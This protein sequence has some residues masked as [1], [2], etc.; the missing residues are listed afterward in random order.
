VSKERRTP[1]QSSRI[2]L[3]NL[4]RFPLSIIAVTLIISC[5][6]KPYDTIEIDELFSASRSPLFVP[7]THAK[8]TR[9]AQA[10]PQGTVVGHDI[11]L[12][13]SPSYVQIYYTADGPRK[14]NGD[15]QLTTL[16][17]SLTVLDNRGE[18]IGK[19][20]GK[21]EI[22][23][24]SLEEETKYEWIKLRVDL[25]NI[26]SRRIRLVLT[27]KH[28]LSSGDRNT[29]QNDDS[30]TSH[31][32]GSK[33]E[34]ATEY[35]SKPEI[36]GD[37]KPFS[38]PNIILVSLDTLRADHLGLYG[39]PRPTSPFL[40]EFGSKAV[41]FSNAHS[42]STWTLPSHWTMMTS[43]HPM[44]HKI[45]EY[46]KTITAVE[47]PTIAEILAD[48]LYQTAAFTNAGYLEPFFGF[49]IGFNHFDASTSDFEVF[50]RAQGWIDQHKGDPFFVFIH[51]FE[52]HNYPLSKKLHGEPYSDK[53]YDGN[54]QGNFWPLLAELFRQEKPVKIT[55]AD[56]AHAINL[57]DGAI[58]LTDQVLSR[59]VNYIEST[60]SLENTVIIITSDHGESFRDMHNG[61]EYEAWHH[62]N[63]PYEEQNHIP[64]II[65]VPDEKI[66]A[67]RRRV[68]EP[69][70]LIDLAPTILDFAGIEAPS[71]F[72]GGSLR[73]TITGRHTKRRTTP[74]FSEQ[75][76]FDLFSVTF[77]D[78]K[79]ISFRTDRDNHFKGRHDELYSLAADPEELT[80]LANRHPDVANSLARMIDEH[81]SRA[82]IG[83]VAEEG[84]V[85]DAKTA[86]ELK[87]L[88]YLQ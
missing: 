67:Q 55:D 39:Y 53:N 58:R 81:I 21:F 14:S 3:K 22:E 88:G 62:G 27:S 79:L 6:Q 63:A 66:E 18:M 28:E 54:F 40:D 80:N 13:G 1:H 45:K 56:V 12:N 33:S 59:F 72:R 17:P 82:D 7:V 29:E 74:I 77:G 46:K 86:E 9:N 61:G 32:S 31:E 19:A 48:N 44:Q 2:A 75:P 10:F 26:R 38:R 11:M 73:S 84:Q 30:P 60:E 47:F 43:L 64:M 69:V 76:N 35:W 87:A 5:V 37:G 65:R 15:P 78:H 52:I 42:E 16:N 51:T 71:I 57:Y 85:I 49:H 23:Q 20:L 8:L 41:V 4:V 83:M 24:G 50:D 70:G 68:D 25:R 34:P 36:V